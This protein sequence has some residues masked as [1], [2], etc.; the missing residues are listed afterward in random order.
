M[1][2]KRRG[3]DGQNSLSRGVP[4]PGIR[5]ADDYR[6]SGS[7]FAQAKKTGASG[8]GFYLFTTSCA[9]R[10]KSPPAL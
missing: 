9:G 2:K 4:K 8:T 7:E 3:D 1:G 6:K 10:I 5:F